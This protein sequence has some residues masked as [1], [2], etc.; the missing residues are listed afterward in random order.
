MNFARITLATAVLALSSV[1]A[2]AADISGAGATF[3][4]PIYA[5]WA[6]AYKKETG[7]GLNYQ[8]IGS[9][10]GIKQ[11]KAK[12]VTFGA[13]D[14]PLTGKD[15]DD[16]GLAQFPMVMGAIVPVVNLEGVK[17]GDLV[18]TTSQEKVGGGASMLRVVPICTWKLW[19]EWEGTGSNAKLLWQSRNPQ[20][21]RVIAKSRWGENG[22]K[23][24]AQESRNFLV[25]LHGSALPAVL[26]FAKTNFGAGKAIYTAMFSKGGNMFDHAYEIGSKKVEGP[27]GTYHV[28]T[29]KNAGPATEDEKVVAADFYTQFS[30]IKDMVHGGQEE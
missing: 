9:G 18:L 21:A 5:K 11:I 20:D 4:Y 23:P 14:A 6:D 16:S 13:S 15:L 12:T 30:G 29:W 24:E 7:I 22:E 8:S 19:Q 2:N 1:V 10:G 25:L 27:K 3:P 17:P 26:T 28:F